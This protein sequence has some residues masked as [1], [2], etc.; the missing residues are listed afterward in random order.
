LCCEYRVVVENQ[1]GFQGINTGED[2][3]LGS[4]GRTIPKFESQKGQYL[5]KELKV[6]KD[7]HEKNNNLQILSMD[8]FYQDIKGDLHR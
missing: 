5:T 2:P 1:R 7:L 8:S 4:L 6:A 3:G